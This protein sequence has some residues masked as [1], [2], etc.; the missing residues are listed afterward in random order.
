M[1]PSTE[2]AEAQSEFAAEILQ[3]LL[4]RITFENQSADPAQGHYTFL[5]SH[6]WT[7]GPMMHLVWKSPP[8]DITWGLVRD[9]RESLI[10]PSPWPDSEEAVRYYYLLDLEEGPAPGYPDQPDTILWCGDRHAGLPKRP[11]EIPE[12]HRYTPPPTPS[13]TDNRRKG[14]RV[15]NEPRHYGNPV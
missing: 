1:C 3:T 11:S 9:T 14:Q 13:P 5:V 2:S 7:E 10:D 6:A 8:S 12:A 15:V 4:R